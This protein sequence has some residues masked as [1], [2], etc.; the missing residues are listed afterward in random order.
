MWQSADLEEQIKAKNLDNRGITQR[1]LAD[2][3]GVDLATVKRIVKKLGL[4]RNCAKW[5]PTKEQKNERKRIAQ[6]LSDWFYRKG[7]RFLREY[8]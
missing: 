2:E 7:E 4:R 1:Q 8:R 5:D 3:A 6:E